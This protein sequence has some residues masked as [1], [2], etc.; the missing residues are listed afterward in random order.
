M[1]WLEQSVPV[2]MLIFCRITS[3]FVVAPIYTARGVPTTFKIGISFIVTVLVFLTF[4]LGQTV[5]QDMS[6]VLLIIQEV[7][8]GLL[9][10]FTAFLMMA[11]VQTAGGLIDIQ[12]GFSMANVIDPITGVSTPLIGNFKYMMALLVF[13]NMNGHHFLLDAI[14]YSYDWMP[15]TGNVFSKIQDGSVTEFL[16]TTFAYS[17]VLALQMSAPIVAAL[18]LTDVGLGFLART[19]PQFNVFVIGIPLKIIVGL[20]LL[21]LLMPGLTG[22]FENLFAEMFEAMRSLLGVIGSKPAL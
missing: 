9:L 11:V 13:L 7:L 22:L 8:I 19:A 6:Y 10:G 15:I 18:F 12:I 4:G 3:F 1:E 2:F 16:I 17:F 21:L 14:M 20:I 5:A